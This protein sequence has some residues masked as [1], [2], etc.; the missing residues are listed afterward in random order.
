MIHKST[1]DD[2]ISQKFITTKMCQP[3]GLKDNN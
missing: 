3:H 1:I 2:Y